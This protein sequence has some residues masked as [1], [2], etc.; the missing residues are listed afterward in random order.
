MDCSPP[1]SSFHGIHQARILG[2]KARFPALQADSFLS[3]PP[4]KPLIVPNQCFVFVALMPLLFFFF[5]WYVSF[6]MVIVFTYQILFFYFDL[7]ASISSL[8]IT[9]ILQ[10][11]TKVSMNGVAK[12]TCHDIS[13]KYWALH[14]HQLKN[15]QQTEQHQHNQKIIYI[16]IQIMVAVPLTS[17]ICYS[18][19]C[20]CQ[21]ES[22]GNFYI[23]YFYFLFFGP[24]FM[25]CGI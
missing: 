9:Y 6:P 12:S 20:F 2:I 4:R 11:F 1:G 15:N 13:Y 21:S 24:Q 8:M 22:T 23:P 5:Y 7:C 16:V 3:E 17:I 19:L 10:S 25:A 18:I 14:E